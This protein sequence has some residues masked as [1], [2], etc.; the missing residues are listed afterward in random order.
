MLVA[1]SIVIISLVLGTQA[2]ASVADQGILAAETETVALRGS[3][4]A[5]P[6]GALFDLS[7]WQLQ[8]PVASGSGVQTISNPALKTYTS[9]YFYTGS[10]GSMTFW[11]PQDGAKTSGS[12]YPR[13]ELR[14]VAAGG[15]WTLK[16]NHQMNV[17]AKILK[18]PQNKKVVIGQIH[19]NGVSGSC[20]VILE[21]EYEAGTLVAHVRDK[22]C[23]NV[24]FTVGKNIAVG[25]TIQYYVQLKDSK[26]IVQTNYGSMS[27]WTVVTNYKLYFKVGDYVQD[28]NPSSSNGGTVAVS[29]LVVKHS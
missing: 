14:E 27:P 3:V 9:K 28:N 17:T 20:S 8:L 16:G 1:C 11:A 19:A 10:D 7:H 29:K 13:S 4:T 26:L 6:P 24:E 22:N 18:V 23:K 15:D 25:A 21:L 12:L 2:S 5:S